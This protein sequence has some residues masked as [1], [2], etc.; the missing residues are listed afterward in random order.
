[1]FRLGRPGLYSLSVI[2][3]S[4]IV[5]VNER[6]RMPLQSAPNTR[7]DQCPAGSQSHSHIFDPQEH[8]FCRSSEH[9]MQDS[10]QRSVQLCFDRHL[11]LQHPG[12]HLGSS[13]NSRFRSCFE[14]TGGEHSLGLGLDH[15]TGT[16]RQQPGTGPRKSVVRYLP[17]QRR[18]CQQFL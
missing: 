5:R 18:K 3:S 4:L 6:F 17:Q 7:F 11:L 13:R 16:Y 8:R 2:P 14:G 15:Y 1:M 10:Y 9:L 12:N